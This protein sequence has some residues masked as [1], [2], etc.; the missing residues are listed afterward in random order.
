MTPSGLEEFWRKDR[1]E[2]SQ[3]GWHVVVQGHVVTQ[4]S[5]QARQVTGGF[6]GRGY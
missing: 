1:K 6:R 5:C 2:K 3:V 4:D